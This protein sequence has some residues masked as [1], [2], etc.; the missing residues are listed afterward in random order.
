M[1]MG[2]GNTCE[3]FSRCMSR[4]PECTCPEFRAD[5]AD[6]ARLLTR[7]LAHV[8]P[9]VP[10]LMKPSNLICRNRPAGAWLRHGY[11]LGRTTIRP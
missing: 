10:S 9:I 4:M 2:F 8:V 1:L 5:V 6:A 11:R 7:Y 3:A